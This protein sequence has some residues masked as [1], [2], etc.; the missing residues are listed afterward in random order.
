M[1][2][3]TPQPARA[4]IDHA[5]IARLNDWL[6]ANITSPGANRIV[7]TAG[8]ANLI[9][10]VA[11]FRGFRKRAELLRTVRDHETFERSIDPHGHRD[12]GAFDFEGTPCLW[13]IDYYDRNLDNGSEN[14]ADPFETVRVLTILCADEW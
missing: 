8:V 10:D 7:M 1:A 3:D 13:K 2:Q 12:M 6:R 14:P 11:L 5:E 9:G 4:P